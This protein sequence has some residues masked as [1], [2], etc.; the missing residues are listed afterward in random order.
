ME[1][2]NAPHEVLHL[3]HPRPVELD[4]VA[5]TLAAELGLPLCPYAEWVD[6]LETEMGDVDMAERDLPALRLLDFF[7][8]MRARWGDASG[9]TLLCEHAVASSPTLKAA[10]PLGAADV[11]SWIAYWRSIGFV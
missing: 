4:F 9:P 7:R 11:Q 8:S 3:V 5:R 6:A 10:V 2:R 1:C